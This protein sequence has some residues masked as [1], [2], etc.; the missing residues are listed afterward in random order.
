MGVTQHILGQIDIDLTGED[1][2]YGENYTLAY[3][4]IDDAA[5]ARDLIISGRY[6][7]RYERRG[8]VWKIAYRSE[9]V[10]WVRDEPA[11]RGL[12]E[13]ASKALVSRAGEM[14]LSERRDR[15]CRPV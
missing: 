9:V 6:I 10:D 14:D 8:G 5:G 1:E 2:A 11:G 13:M 4:R 12:P 3:H 15:L 7:D